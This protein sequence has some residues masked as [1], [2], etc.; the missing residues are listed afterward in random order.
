MRRIISWEDLRQNGERRSKS[1]IRRDIRSGK[2]PKPAGYNGKS[3]IWT[4]EQWDAHVERLTAKHDQEA[5]HATA[6]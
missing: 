4:E 1:Q 5:H 3:P 2:F 6:A